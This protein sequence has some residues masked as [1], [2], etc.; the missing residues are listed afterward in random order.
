[1]WLAMV[2]G[3]RDTSGGTT[4]TRAMTMEMP[5]AVCLISPPMASANSP[6]TV[7]YKIAPMTALVTPGWPSV[8]EM[9]LCRIAVV[10][11]TSRTR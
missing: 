1:M 8:T 7:R 11:K 4:M 2:P 6:S 3:M 9:W 10:R 5:P